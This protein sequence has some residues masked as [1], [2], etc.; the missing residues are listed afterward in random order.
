MLQGEPAEE[1]PLGRAER[2]PL[3]ADVGFHHRAHATAEGVVGMH[4]PAGAFGG[5][6][7][8]GGKQ[9]AV[10]GIRMVPSV[11]RGDATEEVV[12]DGTAAGLRGLAGGVGGPSAT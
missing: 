9:Q 7:R 8:L 4:R 6:S 2:G 1:V 12:D 3:S 5:G 11:K 10:A